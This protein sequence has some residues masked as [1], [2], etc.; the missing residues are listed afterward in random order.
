MCRFN[1][2]FMENVLEQKMSVSAAVQQ[3][4]LRFKK[5]TAGEAHTGDCRGH[6]SL[7]DSKQL[8]H[9][10]NNVCLQAGWRTAASFI[11]QLEAGRGH[12]EGCCTCEGDVVFQGLHI[13]E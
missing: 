10:G 8:Q 5:P 11:H 13:V 7:G 12:S 6:V 4:H 3:K 1:A 2:G 9:V